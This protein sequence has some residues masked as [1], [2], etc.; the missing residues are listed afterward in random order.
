IQRA[1]D[2][3]VPYARQVLH[4][5]AAD[6]ND[7]MFLKIMPLAGDVRRDLLVVAEAH[8]RNLAESRV[9]LLRCGRVHARADAALLGATLER[10]S[11]LHLHLALPALGDQLGDGR[12]TSPCAA[13]ISASKKRGDPGPRRVR[14]EWPDRLKKLRVAPHLVKE[15]P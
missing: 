13:G 2:D 3:V 4:A 15:R 14:L 12:H 9:R 11:L 1:P 10:G 8:A 5:A 6:E 7:R